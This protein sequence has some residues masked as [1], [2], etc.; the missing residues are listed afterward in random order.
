M[1]DADRRSLV[2]EALALLGKRRLVLSIHGASFPSFDDEDIGRGVPANRG[3]RALLALAHDL[4]FDAIQVGPGGETSREDPS[5][6]AST[7]F[8]RST[9]AIDFFGLA[10]NEAWAPFVD[11]TE[12]G[13]AVR[14]NPRRGLRR[15]DHR[16]AFDACRGLLDGIHARFAAARGSAAHSAL[17]ASVARSAARDGDWVERERAA[18]SRAEDPRRYAL[19]QLAARQTHDSFRERAR[20]AGVALL[21]DLAV[22]SPTARAL[23]SES[24][25]ATHVLGAPPSR[26]NPAGQPWGYP[27]LDPE[28][29]REPDGAD[30]PAIAFLR[31]RIAK[32]LDEHDGMRVDHPHGLICPWV[33]PRDAEDPAAAVGSGAR[34]FSA[35]DDPTLARYAIARA[36][37]IAGDVPT[38]ADA[39]VRELDE[40]QVARYAQLVDVIVEELDVRGLDVRDLAC[41]VL[42]TIPYPLARVLER[43]RLGRFRV[44]QKAKLDDPTDPYST[45]TASAGDWVMVGTHDTPPIWRVARGWSEEVRRERARH[46]ARRLAGGAD[47]QREL[48]RS[49]T[50]DVGALV[51]AEVADLFA[52]PAAQV[53]VFFAD[54]FGIEEVYNTP[55]TLS[56]D[57]WTL[58][59]VPAAIER[60]EG[61]R[62]AGRALD[63]GRSLALALRARH[64]ELG[65][66]AIALAARLDRS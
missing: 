9:T 17:D 55:G 34:L 1:A 13:R 45:T 24:F 56:D 35:P 50:A 22:G 29:Y 12:V 40:A 5:P 4:G 49:L 20:A 10:E 44:T 57:N 28:R 39:H 33:Y 48:E 51:H 60:Y 59:L 61:D 16:H 15:C 41:E 30:G 52:C 37:Q 23:S 62:A 2:R 14:D 32:L 58:R 47:E 18:M 25:L 7:F 3:G 31:R 36:D 21:G 46:F 43:H 53:V 38:Y 66:P 26:T 11:T 8:A 64:R 42:S 63:L 54:L 27:V 65:Q 6:Y 19:A